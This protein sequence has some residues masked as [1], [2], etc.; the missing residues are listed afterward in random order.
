MGQQQYITTGDLRY[1]PETGRWV[2]IAGNAIPPYTPTGDAP[3]LEVRQAMIAELQRQG[4]PIP[5]HLQGTP[6]L[7]EPAPELGTGRSP[8]GLHWPPKPH[9]ELSAGGQQQLRTEG[10]DDDERPPPLPEVSIGGTR[11]VV[12]GAGDDLEELP[13]IDRIAE[14]E[15]P[16]KADTERPGP[17]VHRGRGG[18]R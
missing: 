1:D 16:P 10:A 5:P 8:D 3:G 18:R 14:L 15:A 9:P 17:P 13:P 7:V 2:P 11:H 4:L 12:E 6:E